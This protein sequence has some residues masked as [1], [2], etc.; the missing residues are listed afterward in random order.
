MSRWIDCKK[1]MPEVGRLCFGAVYGH[2][3]IIPLDGEDV[4]DA[5]R[6]TM[7]ED[8]RTVVCAWYGEADGWWEDGGMMI[9]TP[10]YWKP[11]R[12]PQPP[13]VK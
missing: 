4:I 3:V 6:R 9:V 2:D 5:V 13:K 8:P 7:D 1:R 12:V 10:R 11:I